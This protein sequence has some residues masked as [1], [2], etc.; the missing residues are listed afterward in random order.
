MKRIDFEK[1]IPYYDNGISKW[2][3]DEYF[4]QYISKEQAFN[5]PP[6]KGLYC[7]IVKAGNIED[8]VLIDGNQNIIARY[9]YNNEGFGQMEAKINIIKINKHFDGKDDI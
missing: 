8:Y 6:I 3:L 1:E 2:Y 5:L 4:N 9:K 7:F